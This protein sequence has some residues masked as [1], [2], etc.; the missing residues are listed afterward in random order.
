VTAVLIATPALLEAAFAEQMLST[1]FNLISLK[2]TLED[3]DG[4]QKDAS[5]ST[6]WKNAAFDFQA[7]SACCSISAF[8]DA[9]GS[10]Q[11][12]TLRTPVSKQPPCD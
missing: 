11:G 7:A 3:E 10:I 8:T 4:R 9:G 5:S 2:L 12:S 6:D 1:A